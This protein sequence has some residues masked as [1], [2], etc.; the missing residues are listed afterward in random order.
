MNTTR[1]VASVM[2]PRTSPEEISRSPAAPGNGVRRKELDEAV[3]GCEI[4]L[5]VMDEV[6]R[7][8]NALVDDRR[9]KVVA[10]NQI[11]QRRAEGPVGQV[12]CIYN[13]NHDMFEALY[14]GILGR[15]RGEI[16]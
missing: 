5:R 10:E 12:V 6:L 1:E 8:F 9:E 14:S 13:N 11:R 15:Y 3:A 7:K 2:R 16:E 4:L